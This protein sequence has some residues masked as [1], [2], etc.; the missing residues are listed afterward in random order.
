MA[1]IL[2]LRPL[3]LPGF[4]IWR[5]MPWILLACLIL[6]LPGCASQ[7]ESNTI[8]RAFAEMASDVPVEAEGVVV[9]I[10]RDDT[11]GSR[12][13]RFIVEI[14][15][16][17]SLLIAHNIDVGKRVPL[18]G[19]GDRVLFRGEYEWNNKGGVVHWTHHA[20]RGNHPGGWI[21]YDGIRY[22]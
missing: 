21:E 8:D 1:K 14:P 3:P 22:D 12:H 10:L 9:K 2:R 7:V 18:N 20:P 4:L 17:L 16:G 15:S 6:P 19:P 11:H 5:W 13:Q